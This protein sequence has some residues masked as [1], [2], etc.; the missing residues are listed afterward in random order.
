MRTMRRHS[1]HKAGIVLALGML[2]TAPSA[3]LGQVHERTPIAKT[4]HFAFYSDFATNLNDA[5]IAA[6]T[7][8]NDGEPELF[9]SGAEE[10]CF[11]ELPP[12]ARAAWD[13]AVDYYAEIISPAGS[14]RQVYLLRVH[15]VGFDEQLEDPKSRQFV[16]I[17]TSFRAAATPAYE[18]CRWA[19][20]DAE[21]R[22]WIEEVKS[23]LAA[24][25]QRI[26]H[27]L[28]KLY[29]EP[30]S[31]LPIPT[32]VVET[33]NWSGAN[34]IYRD[35]AGGHL[36][37][38][39]SYQGLAALEIVFHE[40]S[41]LSMGRGDPLRNALDEASSALDLPLPGDLLHVVLFYTTGEAVRRIL[42]DAGKSEYT[43]I[44]YEIFERS[45]WGRYRDAI[46]STW[47]AYMDGGRT[48]PEA[49]ADLIQAIGEPE[50][51]EGR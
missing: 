38:S 21:N 51:L 19:T 18:A 28:E 13:R 9:H 4:P 40:A 27:R 29:Q 47:P 24:H 39:N 14:N 16:E 46:E 23:Q 49:A 35:P 12:S 34:T 42:D 30:W 15:L 31:G 26:A 43:P 11:G 48:F 8:R 5:L 25:E 6:G 33:V 1:F 50:E 44:I 41:H 32:D 3:G 22:R 2:L 37:I 45:K 7:A 10:P 20:Q 17:A 36:L